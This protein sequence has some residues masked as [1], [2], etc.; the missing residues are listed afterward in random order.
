MS[1][2][3]GWPQYRA[4][5]R[6]LLVNFQVT[7]LAWHSQCNT[8]VN[9]YNTSV[10]LLCGP[11]CGKERRVNAGTPTNRASS[12]TLR[13]FLT[14]LHGCINLMRDNIVYTACCGDWCSNCEQQHGVIMT[15]EVAGISWIDAA[16]CEQAWAN[17]RP[18]TSL[19]TAQYNVKAPVSRY[20]Q[21]LLKCTHH[22]NVH[23]IR[24]TT[25]LP[26]VPLTTEMGGTCWSLVCC[27]R[28]AG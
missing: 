7:G 13:I 4:T 8:S 26:V 18:A 6:K 28:N 16:T 12:S 10:T 17:Q 9:Y 20:A 14:S 5:S 15:S 25:I 21:L 19:S 3:F 22:F 11:L 27:I 23:V 24:R 1:A 2:V